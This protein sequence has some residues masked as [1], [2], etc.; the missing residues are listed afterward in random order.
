MLSCIVLP[1]SLPSNHLAYVFASV[2]PPHPAL[3]TH[4]VPPPGS[5]KENNLDDSAKAQLRDAARNGLTLA[6]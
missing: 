2:G 3:V 4:I 6:L 1:H 5:V